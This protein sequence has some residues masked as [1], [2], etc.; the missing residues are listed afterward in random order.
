VFRKHN[1]RRLEEGITEN[2][3]KGNNSFKTS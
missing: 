1:N 3:L 2:S